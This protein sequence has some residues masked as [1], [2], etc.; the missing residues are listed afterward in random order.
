M[1]VIALNMLGRY[2]GLTVDRHSPEE[3][4]ALLAPHFR[5][6]R[7]DGAGPFPTA[8][9]YSGC[10]GPS[11]TVDAWAEALHARGWA[12][13]RVDSHTPRGLE[14]PQGWALVCA[15]QVLTGAERAG[16]VAVTLAHAA[17]LSF[18]DS[19]R[20]ALVG[21]SHGGWSIM[22]FLSMADNGQVPLT[23]EEWPMGFTGPMTDRVHASFLLYP[24]CGELNRATW[25]G[26]EAQVPMLMLLAEDDVVADPENCLDIV[27]EGAARGLPISA[28]VLDDVT[29]A[30]DHRSTLEFSPSRYDPDAA[31]YALRR[32]GE[33]LD[34]PQTETVKDTGG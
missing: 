4:L 17:A 33:F 22:E 16:D 32:M 23:L 3:L 31:A 18:V 26:W 5:A 10:D 9:L 6:T 34:A 13:I 28:E 20:I 19:R 27:E 29:H 7:P 2:T 30:F 8:L 12:T 25:Q 15:G 1:L 14:E 24:Y 21:A 11:A